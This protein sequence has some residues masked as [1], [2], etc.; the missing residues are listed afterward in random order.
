[1][2]ASSCVPLICSLAI[3]GFNAIYQPAAAGGVP[4]HWHI[5]EVLAGANFGRSKTDS[6]VV[7]QSDILMEQGN[8]FSRLP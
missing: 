5:A 6:L 8:L 2:K 4:Q 7:A 3:N 1:M